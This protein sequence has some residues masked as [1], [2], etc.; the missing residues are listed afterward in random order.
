MVFLVSHDRSYISGISSVLVDNGSTYSSSRIIESLLPHYSFFRMIRVPVNQ[1]YGYGILQGLK[2]ARGDFIGWTHADLQTDPSDILKGYRLLE[3]RGWDPNIYV[4]GRRID[5]RC[6]D[7]LFT[8]GMGLFET[9]YLG[10]PLWDINAQ[11]NLFSQKFF[12]TWKNPPFDFSLDLYA[13][14]MA[15][16]L[17]LEICRF[18]V[19][20]SPRIHGKSHWNTGVR[21][22]I[23]FIRRTLCFSR[24]LKRG[25][26]Q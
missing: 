15:R 22:K 21:S 9:L 14:Y 11:P 8:F 10:K 6:S 5:R 1:G 20:F 26:I 19:L 24:N 2:C 16:T 3:Q 4:K 25:G 23:K 13:L 18:D 7:R 12:C 17:H